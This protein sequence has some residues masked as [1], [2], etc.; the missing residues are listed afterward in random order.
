MATNETIGYDYRNDAPIYYW[1]NLSSLYINPA[2]HLG[3]QRQR[4]IISEKHISEEILDIDSL[5]VK[6]SGDTLIVA[7]HG[8]LVREKVELPRFE[9]VNSLK[10]RTEHQ[11]FIADTSL[12]ESKILTLG[13]YVGT[14][15]DDYTRKIADFVIKVKKLL[16]L[17]KVIF[18]GSSG[19]GFASMSIATYI[20]D[21]NVVCFTP[22]TNVWK[23]TEGHS[24]NLLNESFADFDNIN[25]L[26]N[27][28]PKRFSLIERYKKARRLNK[29]IYIQN[30]GDTDHYE[31]HFKPFAKSLGVKTDNGRT[32]DQSGRFIS[33]H[34]GAG[35]V[36]PPK[37][38]VHEFLDLAIADLD[39]PKKSPMAS[40][41]FNG[42]LRDHQFILGNN[43]FH[44]VDHSQ[45]SYYLVS[46]PKLGYSAHNLAYSNEGVPLRIIDG[47]QYDHPVLQAQYILKQLNTLHRGIDPEVEAA[48]RATV[49]RWKQY[50]VSSRGAAF[51]PYSFPWHGEAQT[52]PWY[53]AMAQGQIL[54]ALARIYEIFPEYEIKN[55]ADEVFQSF[56][57]LPESDPSIPW[58]VDIDQDGYLWLEEYPGVDRGKFV[59]NGHLFAVWGLY[60]YWRV[61][62]NARAYTL[63]SAG[64]ETTKN[65][66]YL[67]RNPN[68]ASHYDLTDFLLLRNYHQTHISQL[69]MTYNLT[70]D[71]FYLKIADLLESDFPSYQRDGSMYLAEGSH[72][73]LELDHFSLPTKKINAEVISLEEATAFNFSTRTKVEELDGIWLRF[74]D[75]SHQGK[76]VKEEA[77]NVFPRLCF[78]RHYYQRPRQVLLGI[79]IVEHNTFNRWGS[80][81]DRTAVNIEKPRV[82]SVR[83]RAYWNG[84]LYFEI[85]EQEESFEIPKGRWIRENI[86]ISA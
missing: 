59:V 80:A 62:N 42:R 15:H 67:S 20:E 36:A 2:D 30:L 41:M 1:E 52:P 47:I 4:H 76:W 86:P 10:S 53:S 81:I 57:L 82:I 8:A 72:E 12:N 31:K 78:D 35:H 13:W 6:G 55:F 29:F 73:V 34:H 48:V 5:Y 46:N 11:L 45:N 50:A 74:A 85:G 61:F 64:L 66:I 25:E 16:K 3:P 27:Q 58:V 68:W 9:W 7:L 69:E 39:A 40:A 65:Y 28:F 19:G 38:K 23:F 75:G 49:M 77:P 33:F 83:S 51:F 63:A 43:T 24:K 71:A 84:V 17:K 44:R 79:G 26:H 54:S 70:G 21:S 37:E 56:E 14:A 18:L 22:Q 60:D 32:F